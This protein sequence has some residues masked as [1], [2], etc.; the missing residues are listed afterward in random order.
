[1]DEMNG[2]DEEKEKLHVDAFLKRLFRKFKT[3][4]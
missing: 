4:I 2:K 1:M 3:Y